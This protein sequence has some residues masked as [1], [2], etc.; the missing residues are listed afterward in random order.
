M[1]LFTSHCNK[2]LPA[3]LAMSFL[4]QPDIARADD[5]NWHGYISQGAIYTTKNEFFG[6]S[7]DVSWD[8]NSVIGGV[9]WDATKRL[10]FSAQAIYR[11]AGETSPDKVYTD[12]AMI[13]FNL[14]D[15]LQ[16]QM[17]IRAGRIKNPYGFFTDTRDIAANRSSVLLPESVYYDS[18]RDVFHTSDSISLYGS[19]Y[20]GQHLIQV[21]ALSGK[22]L[23]TEASANEFTI[24]LGIKGDFEGKDARIFRIMTESYGGK[25]RLAYTRAETLV[26]F[27]PDPGTREITV[28]PGVT[29]TAPLN[30][31]PGKTRTKINIWSIEFNYGQWQF[32]SEI[33]DWNLRRKDSSPRGGTEYDSLGMYGSIHYRINP[34]LQVYIRRDIL[35]RNTDDKD[36]EKYAAATGNPAHNQYAF[37]TTVGVKFEPDDHWHLAL[38]AHHVRGTAWLSYNDN[39]LSQASKKW[40]MIAAEVSYRF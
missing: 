19:W 11:Q 22:P 6:N 30:G 37:D 3:A 27:T 31:Y 24:P 7:E 25:L 29:M 34:Q 36:G 23:F 35:Y 8:F 2:L 38:E 39:D 4:L 5:W 32:T 10:R 21:D 18:L 26:K 1:S 28:S 12:Y 9:S 16:G 33:L 40:T 13:D 17:G 14:I 20:W 15:N